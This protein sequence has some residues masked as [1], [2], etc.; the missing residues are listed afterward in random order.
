[1][2]YHPSIFGASSIRGI[3][4]D[5]KTMTR[6]IVKRSN[7]IVDVRRRSES[8]WC[9]LD[10]S[11]AFIDPGPSLT[12]NPGPYLK[13]PRRE[14]ETVHRVYSVYQPGDRLW[15]R[16]MFA[17]QPAEYEWNVST[18]IP[19]IPAETWYRADFANGESYNA[20]MPWRPSIH[21]PRS[22]SRITLE[23]ESVR[24]ERL[25]DITE[26]DAKAEGAEWVKEDHIPLHSYQRGFESIWTSLYGHGSWEANPWVWVIKF[27][28]VES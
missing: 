8:D 9:S 23:I 16:E 5:A 10:F 4:A 26:A 27:K 19:R 15:V 28:R 20:T 2:K 7:S 22:L 17:H 18:S 25:R 12:G 6:R 11:A 1:M 21:M 13:V 24:P 3:L 14:L